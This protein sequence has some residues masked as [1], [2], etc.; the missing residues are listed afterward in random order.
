MS[1]IISI[2]TLDGRAIQFVD[3]IK[4][5]GGM[6][7]V[8]FS[9]NKDYV[10]AFFRVPADDATRE[11]LIVITDT[12]RKNIL[13]QIGGEYWKNLF[14]WP[15]NT[16]E[17]NGKLGIVAPFYD[18]DFF[19]KYGSRNNDMLN[20]V[21]KEK[22][23]KWFASASNRNKFLD[24]RE[25]GSWL[26]NL[27]MCLTIARAVR[28]MHSAGL[29]HS[30]LS[31][32][33][34]LIDPTTGKACLIDIDGLV[35]PGKYPP[36]VVGTPDFI[37]PECVATSHLDKNDPNRK[38][39][40]IA[41]DRHAL[42]VLIYMY[43]LFRH[44]LRGDKIHSTD[45]MSDEELGMGEKALFIEDPNDKT[46]T[47]KVSNVKSTELPWKDLS[48]IPY[49]ITGPYLSELILRAFTKGL[50]NPSLR[51][52]ADE[53]ESAL[54]KS[55]DLLQPCS[56]TSCEQRWFI[57]DNKTKPVCPFCKTSFQG[58]LP[59]LNLYSS[60]KDN[61]FKPDN[62]RLMVYT[63]QSLFQ[64]HINRNIVPNER[65]TDDQKKRVGY[66]VK[67]NNLWYLVN[68]KMPQLY[69]VKHKLDVPIG[70][71]VVLDDQTQ[72]LMSKEDGGRLIIVQIANS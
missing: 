26:L 71:K 29:A 12:Y 58:S 40:C 46:N 18:S 51:P 8:Y 56:N 42:A 20:I 52:T 57:F 64:W 47:I 55:M 65:L 7:D 22:E 24:R 32:K 15:T 6:K 60:R 21:G 5:S 69:D 1:N 38:L 28:R 34:V 37:A 3:E 48:L 39:P 27:K 2:N 16:V 68:E 33:N 67:H 72:L 54:V 53:W 70:A 9:P 50:H 25:L 30:D 44:P 35:V 31:Y 41:T 19:F 4:A 13:N 61:N 59:V 10:V 36:D 23:G 45:P 62:H 49:S 14:C 43:L 63:N 11:R 66:F 17:Y